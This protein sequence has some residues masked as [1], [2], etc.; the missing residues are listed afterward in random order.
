VD[1]V[2]V[3]EASDIERAYRE[4]GTRLWWAV[5]AYTGNAEMAS[6]AV[7][8]AFARAL[9]SA[10]EIRDPVSWAWRVA[11][12]VATAELKRRREWPIEA[13]MITDIDEQAIDVM[14]A[15]SRLSPRQR[16]VLV[17]FYLEDR[18]T[19]QIA[20]TLAMSPATVSVH[21][22]RARRKLRTIL[23]DEDD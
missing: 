16:A 23:G 21:L 22:H 6:D 20:Q 14:V 1:E 13:E 5:L 9:A 15:L 3:T 8:E 7:A 19:K 12:R 17:L 10:A 2:D 18:T 4:T 11:F